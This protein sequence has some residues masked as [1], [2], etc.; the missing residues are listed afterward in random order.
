MANLERFTAPLGDNGAAL[1]TKVDSSVG[2][3][4]ELLQQFVM[5]GQALN[6]QEGTV[7]LLLHDPELY[8]HLN[9]AACNIEKITRELQPIIRDARVFADKIARHPE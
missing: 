1:I 4:D 3:L 6:R 2:H 9:A 7:G 5:F 8:R